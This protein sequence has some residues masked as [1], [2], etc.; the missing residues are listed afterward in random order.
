MRESVEAKCRKS[1]DLQFLF[2]SG[3]VV[4]QKRK[5]TVTLSLALVLS[6]MASAC[7]KGGTSTTESA[8]EASKEPKKNAAAEPAELTFFTMGGESQ[9]SFNDRYGNAI[10]K[11]FPNYTIKYIRSEKGTTLPEL[12]ASGTKIDIY[13]DS[14]GNF[15]D[16]L[17]GYQMQYDMSDLIKKSGIDLTKFEPTLIDA[18]REISGGKMYGLPVYN[19]NLILFYNKAVFDK[20]GVS[21]P[22]DGMTWDETLELAKKLNRKDGDKQYLGLSVSPTHM[23]RM[24]QFS[25]PYVDPKTNKPVLDNEKWRKLYQTTMID[26]AQD[27]GYKDRITELKNDLP[28][29]DALLKDQ[30][31]GMFVFLSAMPFTVAEEITPLNWDMVSLPTFKEKPGIGSQ[32]YPTY[33]SI[34]SMAGNKDAAIEVMKFLT[35]ADYQTDLSKKGTMPVLKDESIIKVFGQDTKFKGKNFNAAFYNKFAPISAKTIYDVTVEKSYTKQIGLMAKGE[36]DINTA[37]RAAI[38]EAEK[39]ITEVKARTGAK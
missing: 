37:F 5:L 23:L 1:T 36:I 19:T 31:L 7:G 9:D 6:M 13:Y 4:L 2:R 27:Q 17:F 10:R 12:I 11:Q 24:N 18:M 38:E 3:G 21:Y 32:A 22:K 30:T 14:I 33:F 16:G 39:G 34:T 20:F 25:Q 26:P 15:S 8:G 28:Y 35:S 29:R